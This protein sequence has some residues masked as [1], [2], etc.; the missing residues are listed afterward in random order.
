MRRDEGERG[1]L[2]ACLYEAQRYVSFLT[3]DVKRGVNA[4]HKR[5]KTINDQRV[6]SAQQ[7]A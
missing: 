5:N 4:S 1:F 7:E 2:I 3:I 6:F